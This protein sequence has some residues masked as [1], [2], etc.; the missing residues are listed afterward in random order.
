MAMIRTKRGKD[1]TRKRGE[2]REDRLMENIRA[3]V[4]N[5]GGSQQASG[6]RLVLGIAVVVSRRSP[7]A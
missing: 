5:R 7:R 2:V 4:Y 1:S 6:R 3:G